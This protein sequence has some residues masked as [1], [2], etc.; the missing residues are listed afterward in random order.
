M[1][2]RHGMGCY[3]RIDIKSLDCRLSML[4]KLGH[5]FGGLLWKAYKKRGTHG[6]ASYKT[7]ATYSDR[8]G[9]SIV[10]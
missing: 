3:K 7:L 4:Y 9:V 1:R 6:V 5:L 8:K 10:S 2:D